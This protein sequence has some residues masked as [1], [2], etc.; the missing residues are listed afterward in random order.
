MTRVLLALSVLILWW[1]SSYTVGSRLLHDLVKQSHPWDL[2]VCQICCKSPPKGEEYKSNPLGMPGP[3]PLGL[4]IDKCI[5]GMTQH[6]EFVFYVQF[7]QWFT[8]ATEAKEKAKIFLMSLHVVI[9]N[10]PASGCKEF[11]AF[12]CGSIV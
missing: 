12:V 4:N 7:M 3:P 11:S 1:T 5:Y 6:F 2:V 9:L 10:K 8:N